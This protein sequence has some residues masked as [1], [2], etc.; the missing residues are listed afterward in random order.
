MASEKRSLRLLLLGGTREARELAERLAHDERWSVISSLAGRTS[1]PERL[2]GQVR[3]GGFGGV[4]GLAG[5]LSRNQI[6]VIVDATHPFAEV[7]SH[8]ALSAAMQT[9]VPHLRFCRPPWQPGVGDQWLMARDV[10]HAAELIDPGAHVLLTIGRQELA[11]FLQ[12]DDVHVVARMIEAPEQG[13]PRHVEIVLA[14]P[15]FTVPDELALLRDRRI[16]VL[17]TKNAGGASVEAKLTAARQLGLPVI[18]IE[19]PHD[20]PRADAETV[21][22]LMHLLDAHHAT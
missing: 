13:V 9:G 2:A 11:P 4:V 7:I 15:P 5:Y 17:V 3:V 14:R 6:D 19:R 20:A 1:E 22:Q 21:T 12:R 16:N 18:M 10:Q 8:N